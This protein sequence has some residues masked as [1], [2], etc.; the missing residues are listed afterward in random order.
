MKASAILA[1][2]R[3]DS[4]GQLVHNGQEIAVAI[5]CLD[6]I[7]ASAVRE[8]ARAYAVEKGVAEPADG[9][10]IY[11]MAVMAHTLLI[12]VLDAE[13]PADNREP[14]FVSFDEVRART[15]EQIAH[16]YEQQRRV[17]ELADPKVHGLKPE[18]L[19]A[20]AFAIGTASEVESARFFSRLGPATQWRSMRFMAS[21]L[22]E[23]QMLKWPRSS[24]EAPTSPS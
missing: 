4:P 11:D 12:A 18:E 22:H 21:L 6:T 10:P 24:P 5:R 3:G 1:G 7:E 2:V 23:R 9:E 14:F 17:Q 16:L 8:K 20:T 15:P 19:M 13:S